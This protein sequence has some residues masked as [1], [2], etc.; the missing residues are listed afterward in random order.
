M[1]DE[2]WNEEK[3]II[4]ILE[5]IIKNVGGPVLHTHFKK[6]YV[7]TGE[8][9]TLYLGGTGCGKTRCGTTPNVR[10]CIEA[11]E[12]VI[13]VDIKGDIYKNVRPYIDDNKYNVVT[14]DFRDINYTACWNPLDL[15]M[16]YYYSTNEDDRQY[17]DALLQN[18]AQALYPIGDKISDPFWLTSARSVFVGVVSLLLEVAADNPSLVTITNVYNIIAEGDKRFG[19][20]SYLKE[21]IALLDANSVA[22]MQLQS[23][24]TTA[25]ETRGGIRSVFLEG[26]SNFAKSEGLK[27]FSA[28]CD[29][30]IHDLKGDMPTAIFIILPDETPI[31]DKIA[32]VL[33]NQ[34]LNHYIRMAQ[35]DYNGRLPVRVNVILEELGNIGAALQNLPH[36]MSA[37]RS[38]NIRINMVLQSLSQLNDLYGNATATTIVSNT[39]ILVAFRTNHWDTLVELSKK[40]GNRKV[41]VDGRLVTE[42][43]I[44]ETQLGA[45]ATRQA[46]IMISGR[47]K[48]IETFPDYSEMFDCTY[49]TEPKPCERKP[50]K[51]A[52]RFDIIE[53]VKEKKQEKQERERRLEMEK[54]QEDMLKA[55][56]SEVRNPFVPV[57]PFDLPQRS[58]DDL[59]K[60]ID[61]Q[62]EKLEKE[63][64]MEKAREKEKKKKR[65]KNDEDEG[66]KDKAQNKGK[67][68]EGKNNK[69]HNKKDDDE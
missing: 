44:T 26:I 41:M 69:K 65:S 40:C 20:S 37:A 9:H 6:P 35:T 57:P 63:E 45:L 38:R 34:L 58:I 27:N 43:L 18:L 7:Y 11:G 10:S 12:T 59:I 22:A 52:E 56:K 32:S 55:E 2:S 31:Y 30:C 60:D 48:Y 24:I 46:L 3:D 23:Y 16:Y 62:I 36:L 19:A 14:M 67:D 53:Y 15:I 49:Q 50:H 17:A 33:M 54:L 51:K 61:R 68:G 28:N 66:K 21:L 4:S 47:T 29:L 39:D 13:T 64:E 42:P 1:R 25:E 8:G 5:S